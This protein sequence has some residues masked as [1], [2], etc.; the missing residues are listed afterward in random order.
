[1]A[2]LAIALLGLALVG[3]EAHAGPL[4]AQGTFATL[5]STVGIAAIVEPA[6]VVRRRAVVRRPPV[7]R[8]RV[9]R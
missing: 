6:V 5:Y 4:S 8:R 9:V 2:G 3:S 1:M 7:V